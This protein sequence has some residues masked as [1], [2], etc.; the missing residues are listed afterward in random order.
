MHNLLL[1]VFLFLLSLS[2]GVS[3]ADSQSSSG[4]QK[5][6][7]IDAVHIEG[8]MN[9]LITATGRAVASQPNL[10]ITADQIQYLVP[11]ERCTALGNV[12]IERGTEL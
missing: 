2:V 9:E 7:E 5:T 3:Y 8:F 1:L 12:V 10:T 4:A 11:D 6:T